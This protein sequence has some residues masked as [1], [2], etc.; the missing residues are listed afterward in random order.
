MD[1]NKFYVY[2]NTTE[3][4]IG[5]FFPCDKVEEIP[6]STDAPYIETR[7]KVEGVMK[8]Y[9][10]HYGDNKI[11]R[12]GHTYYRHFDGYDSMAPI[13]CKY[14]ACDEFTPKEGEDDGQN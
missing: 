12:C 11:C 1:K 14:C 9:N 13:G 8:Q 2:V 7:V 4:S 6:I 5:F 10:P 3:D